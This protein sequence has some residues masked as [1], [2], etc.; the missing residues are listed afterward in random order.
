MIYN[1]AYIRPNLPI[2]ISVSDDVKFIDL[3]LYGFGVAKGHIQA[4][5]QV[6]LQ[7][8]KAPLILNGSFI[9][10]FVNPSSK[11]R[12]L[13]LNSVICAFEMFK[14]RSRLVLY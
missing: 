9:L 10:F 7:D 11:E 2:D 8:N 6:V 5:R 13:L 14:D 1:V 3:S 4:E 12:S